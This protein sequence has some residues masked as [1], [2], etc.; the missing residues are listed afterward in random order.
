V[1]V[2]RF[3]ELVEAAAVAADEGC[4]TQ[5]Q[6][7]TVEVLRRPVESTPRCPPLYGGEV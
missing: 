1:D 7:L 6:L 3:W 5:A 4:E 2:D